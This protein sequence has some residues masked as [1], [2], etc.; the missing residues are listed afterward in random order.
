[1]ANENQKVTDDTT[2]KCTEQDTRTPE[3]ATKLD[4]S[5]QA[6]ERNC[7]KSANQRQTQS[8]SEPHN[9]LPTSKTTDPAMFLLDRLSD[10]LRDGAT[11]EGAGSAESRGVFVMVSKNVAVGVK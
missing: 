6:S 9:I 4:S 3:L 7:P 1:M 10:T 8:E 5:T 11:G 2:K